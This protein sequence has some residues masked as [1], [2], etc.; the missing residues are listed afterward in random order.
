MGTMHDVNATVGAVKIPTGINMRNNM[1]IYASGEDCLGDLSLAV[2]NCF[3]YFRPIWLLD[4]HPTNPWAI[5][6]NESPKVVAKYRLPLW[7]SGVGGGNRQHVDGSMKGYY[8]SGAADKYGKV[9]VQGTPPITAATTNMFGLTEA[10]KSFSFTGPF[11]DGGNITEVTIEGYSPVAGTCYI[12]GIQLFWKALTTDLL[13]GPYGAA[14][15]INEFLPCDVTH[16]ATEGNPATVE[17]VRRLLVDLFELI[18]RRTPL[19]IVTW[20]NL[21]NPRSVSWGGVSAEYLE[22]VMCRL[23]T[24]QVPLV[25]EVE[26]HC[27]FKSPR[28]LRV[29]VG[30]WWVDLVSPAPDDYVW[31]SGVI[32]VDPINEPFSMMRDFRVITGL[33]AGATYIKTL[34]AWWRPVP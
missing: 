2:N 28:P 1:L 13:D 12:T 15:F 27:L 20:S 26:V 8:T 29:K 31:A 11:D 9:I 18:R 19:P 3:N 34:C 7:P 33:T 32:R 30:N 6:D 5:P 17:R 4:A 21:A 24:M 10:E 25:N 14:T 23:R 22:Y 16:L